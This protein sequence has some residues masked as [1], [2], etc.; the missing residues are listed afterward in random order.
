MVGQ[1]ENVDLSVKC[2]GVVDKETE[3]LDK[4]QKKENEFLRCRS[5]KKGLIPMK[6]RFVL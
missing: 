2:G 3:R 4:E 5:L 1:I 6:K